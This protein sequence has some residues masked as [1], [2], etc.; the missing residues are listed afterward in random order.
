MYISTD[1]VIEISK[2]IGALGVIG[3]VVLAIYKVFQ[4]PKEQE[5]EIKSIREKHEKDVNSIREELCVVN[6]ALLAVLDGLKQLN[7]NGKVT[8][9]HNQLSKHLNKQA[10][11][12]T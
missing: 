2:F 11:D 8:E 4:T 12:Q 5:K 1:T 9:A 3:G 10:H 7:C 6:F